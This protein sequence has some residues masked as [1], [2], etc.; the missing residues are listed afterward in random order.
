MDRFMVWAND[1]QEITIQ[2]SILTISPFYISTVGIY[3]VG[4]CR[5]L[6]FFC[7]I[8]FGFALIRLRSL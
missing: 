1:N 6:G 3:G 7:S 4:F 2:L 8:P 5:V